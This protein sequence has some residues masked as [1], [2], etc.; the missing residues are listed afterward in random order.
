[1]PGL[2]R[3]ATSQ[4]YSRLCNCEAAATSKMPHAVPLRLLPEQRPIACYNSRRTAA[5]CKQNCGARLFRHSSH[6]R[7][8]SEL[9]SIIAWQR[10]GG[11]DQHCGFCTAS[12]LN[13]CW[14]PACRR[15][16]RVEVS[17]PDSAECL[18]RHSSEFC[19]CPFKRDSSCSDYLLL[20][21]SGHFSEIVALDLQKT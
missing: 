14:C 16:L 21:S 1:M 18:W 17:S 15:R 11:F 10:N 6:K 4:P 3:P 12:R 7:R 20:G 8:Y 2:Q 9:L 5:S 13:W 19:C